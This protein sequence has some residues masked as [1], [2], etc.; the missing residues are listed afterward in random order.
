MTGNSVII[1]QAQH[2]NPKICRDLLKNQGAV[3]I[4]CYDFGELTIFA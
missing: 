4:P 3:I 2:K 1:K